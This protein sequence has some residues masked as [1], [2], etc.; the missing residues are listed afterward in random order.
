MI[1]VIADDITGAAEIAG[2][3][4]RYGLMTSLII[5]TP[6]NISNLNPADTRGDNPSVATAIT[7]VA[8]DTRSYSAEQAAA[9]TD[10]V[11]KKFSALWS[12]DGDILF[13][14]TDSALRGNVE[15][16]AEAIIRNTGYEQTLFIPANPSKGRTISGGVYYINGVKLSD[17][18][19]SFDPEF[20]AWS[21]SMSER[22]PTLSTCDATCDADID[23]A[24]AEAL[25]GRHTL[26]AG[27]ADLFCSLLR[28]EGHSEHPQEVFSVQKSPIPSMI[29]VR[30]STQ[31]K[32]LDLGL[33]VESMPLDVFYEEAAPCTWAAAIMGRYRRDM[34][35]ADGKAPHGV[36]LTIGDK[37]VRPGKEAAVYL[38]EAMAEVCCTLIDA[39]T[40]D[41]LIIEGGATAFAILSKLP[42]TA[43]SVTHEI[44][45][46]VVRLAVESNSVRMGIILKPG[47]YAWG[48][49]F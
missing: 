31:S 19:F 10:A 43:F 41:E 6:D 23:K 3:G 46:G 28:H 17:T 48:K 20:P 18:D 42:F 37:E 2:I 34:E 38:R 5:V 16:E 35:Q 12:N 9:F 45:P 49:L 14:K 29:V 47:S 44:A 7:V 8:T 13:K 25:A 1:T 30:G 21:S 24:V 26:L 33:A 36:V 40:P 22:F 39:N 11:M 4:H 27:A 15:A 32:A